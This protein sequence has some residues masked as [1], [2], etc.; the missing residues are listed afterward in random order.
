M[1]S[2]REARRRTTDAPTVNGIPVNLAAGPCIEVWAD[3]GAPCPSFSA[4]RNWQDA[5]NEWAA[6]NGLDLPGDY[7]HLPRELC[8][9]APFSRAERDAPAD[10]GSGL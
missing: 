2:R 1:S 6:A 10:A 8:A 5:R 7:R 9:R 3:P 4:L